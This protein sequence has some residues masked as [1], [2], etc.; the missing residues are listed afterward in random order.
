MEVRRAAPED[1]EAM[2]DVYEDVAAERVHIGAEPPV[3]RDRARRRL[4]E[5]TRDDGAG[6]AFVLE[7][8]G[9]IVG[10]AGLHGTGLVE[11]G[12]CI[13]AAARGRGGGRALMEACLEWA[14]ANGAYKIALQVWP[15][16]ERAIALYRKFGFE[17]EGY[18]RKHWRRRNGEL[19]DS[20][21]MG[22]VL[23]E[24]AAGPRRMRR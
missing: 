19:W 24:D 8:D 3:D 6:A 23:D 17:Q 5:I 21:V 10:F 4:G 22:L 2:I 11:L 7:D 15:H 9:R 14:R 12:M 20:I 13:V 18:L 1:V 16:N